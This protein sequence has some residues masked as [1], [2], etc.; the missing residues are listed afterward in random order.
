MLP[1][2]PEP[3]PLLVFPAE[4]AHE[5]ESR[6]AAEVAAVDDVELL[7]EYE[8][9][10]DALRQYLAHTEAYLPMLGVMRRIEARIGQLLG[11]APGRGK[12]EM[13][14]HADSFHQQTREDFRQLG[15]A[16]DDGLLVLDEVDPPDADEVDVT[17]RHSRR[18]LLAAIR[19]GDFNETLGRLKGSTSVEWYTPAEY[20][21]AARAVLG[22]IDLDPASSQLANRTVKARRFYD[23]LD[24]GLAQDW[25]GRVWLNPPYGLA[26]AQFTAKLVEEWE[27]GNVTAAVLLINAYG[28]DAVWFRPLWEHLLCLTDHRIVFT[29]PQ[30]GTGGPANGNLFVYLGDQWERF[31]REFGRFGTIAARW[32][33]VA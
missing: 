23:E 14:H 10:A 33:A 13:S 26:T 27:A 28:F 17:W 29:S 31:A 4:R 19:V 1:A 25:H 24:D 20:V 6:V 12:A 3:R 22:A 18:A 8:R 30:R 21:E 32:E 15:R 5:L 16:V 9:R 11:P 2:L 7:I